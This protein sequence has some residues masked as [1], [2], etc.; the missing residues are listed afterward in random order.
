MVKVT[1]EGLYATQLA[2]MRRQDKLEKDMES[3]KNRLPVWV[4]IT[5]TVMGSLLTGLIV[6]G[7]G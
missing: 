7:L 1:L 2:Q 6:K 4:T 3:L 5:F